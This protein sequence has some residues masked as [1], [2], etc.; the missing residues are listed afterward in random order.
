M[1]LR[2][3]WHG[4]RQDGEKMTRGQGR[5]RATGE[6]GEEGDE[7]EEA[8][9]AVRWTGEGRWARALRMKTWKRVYEDSPRDVE[10]GEEEDAATIEDE[11]TRAGDRRE[12]G[13]TMAIGQAS[14]GN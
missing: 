8:V 12:P 5:G 6:T 4:E 13:T 2:M 7:V 14:S 10:E 3:G 11:R 1:T 9:A